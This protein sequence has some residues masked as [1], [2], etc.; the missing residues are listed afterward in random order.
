M[1]IARATIA[2]QVGGTTALGCKDVK[3][4]DKTKMVDFTTYG[5]LGTARAPTIDD[6]DFSATFIEDALDAGQNKIR[7]SK[8]AHTKLE[9][10]VTKAAVI[11]T[12]SA[13]VESLSRTSGPGDE[14]ILEVVFSP[15]GGVAISE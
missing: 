12:L 5:D 11:H 8:V 3:I 9:Y 14:Q 6:A 1:A 7:Q 13:Y 2:F 15:S 10:I 4:P